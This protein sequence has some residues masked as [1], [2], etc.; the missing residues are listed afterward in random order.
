MPSVMLVREGAT[1]LSIFPPP[2]LHTAH[3]QWVLEL[4]KRMAI[5][6]TAAYTSHDDFNYGGS[7][8]FAFDISPLEESV[9]EARRMV[10]RLGGEM[11]RRS[12]GEL[13]VW[14]RQHPSPLEVPRRVSYAK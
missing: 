1:D 7:T 6:D 12:E 9:E 14:I 11:R 4:H 10:W 2:D 5:L 3:D 8:S 13:P